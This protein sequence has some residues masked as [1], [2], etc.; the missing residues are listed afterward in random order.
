MLYVI[1]GY[2]LTP[3]S[4][5]LLRENHRPV[6]SHCQTLLHNVASST[7]CHETDSNSQH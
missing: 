4:T 7:P 3:L 2:G 6:A 1:E 5:R